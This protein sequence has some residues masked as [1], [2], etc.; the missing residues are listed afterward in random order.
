VQ[1]VSIWLRKRLHYV[2]IDGANSYVRDLLQGTIQG[3]I[4]GL[5]LYAIFVSPLFDVEYFLAFAD[6]NYIPKYNIS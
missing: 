5:I 1:L 4:L 3:S 2:S 6:D